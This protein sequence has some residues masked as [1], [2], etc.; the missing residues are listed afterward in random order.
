MVAVGGGSGVRWCTVVLFLSNSASVH[1][2]LRSKYDKNCH[3]HGLSFRSP[4]ASAPT[5]SLDPAGLL[6][7]TLIFDPLCRKLRQAKFRWER[8][9]GPA[10]SFD[11]ELEP[12]NGVLKG[13]EASARAHYRNRGENEGEG[14]FFRQ[15]A[16]Y[17]TNPLRSRHFPL[18]RHTVMGRRVFGHLSRVSLRCV[19]A[20]QPYH[21]GSTISTLSVPTRLDSPRYVQVDHSLGFR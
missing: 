10:A 8:P 17:A 11:L 6:G 21:R 19:Q 1:R 20:A 3:T 12:A 4:A 7:V 13:K 9:G 18:L 2:R 5:R 14:S 15:Q 16:T